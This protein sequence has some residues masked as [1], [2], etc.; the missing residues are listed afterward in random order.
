MKKQSENNPVVIGALLVV[1]AGAVVVIFRSFTPQ[2][3]LIFMP[4]PA[5]AAPS[6]SAA[7]PLESGTLTAARDPFFHSDIQRIAAAGE[8]LDAPTGTAAD[9]GAFPAPDAFDSPLLAGGTPNPAKKTPAAKVS[10]ASLTA[11]RPAPPE[12][13]DCGE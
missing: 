1:L 9:G 3:D 10:P 7:S 8:K 12:S 5:P 4:A 11:K 6:V 2:S 13:G